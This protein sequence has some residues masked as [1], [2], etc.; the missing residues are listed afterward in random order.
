MLHPFELFIAGLCVVAAIPLLAGAPAANSVERLLPE[1]L[2][3][4]WGSELV[5]GGVLVAYGVFRPRTHW[6]RIGHQLLAPA[7]L[8]YSLCIITVL[9]IGGIVAASIVLGFSLACFM[10]AAVLR[11]AESV[12]RASIDPDDTS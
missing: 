6:E 8:V 9:G 7:A 2:V 3:K 4:V 11:I 10:R 5:V 1:F 12:I